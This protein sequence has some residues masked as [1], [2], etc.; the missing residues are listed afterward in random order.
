[1]ATSADNK[2][3]IFF[4]RK[5]DLD[6]SCKLS[7]LETRCMK[8]QNL[9]SGKSNK[10]VSVCGLLNILP[11]SLLGF[12]NSGFCTIAN[13]IVLIQERVN[14]MYAQIVYKDKNLLDLNNK[15]LEQERK[16]IDI[17]ELVGEKNE[18]IRGRDKVIEVLF[19][20]FR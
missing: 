6:I 5:Q 14:Q 13:F 11:T 4:P 8:C 9:Y 7:P 18:V 17:Q 19:H 3:V 10:N 15:L 2:S 1:M 16:M 20:D 12:G